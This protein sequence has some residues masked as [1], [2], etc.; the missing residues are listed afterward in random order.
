MKAKE[1]IKWIQDN[2]LEEYEI[3]AGGETG[4]TCWELDN[5][6]LKYVEEKEDWYYRGMHHTTDFGKANAI[7]V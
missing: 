6:R 1:L 2:N 5:V 7:V 3:Y 4:N